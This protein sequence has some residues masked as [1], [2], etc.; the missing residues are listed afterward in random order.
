MTGGI[1]HILFA[2]GDICC[3]ICV[4]EKCKG[5]LILE[6]LWGDFPLYLLYTALDTH[7][8]VVDVSSYRPT[9]LPQYVEL[10][11]LYTY[12]LTFNTIQRIQQTYPSPR[13]RLEYGGFCTIILQP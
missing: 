7:L 4:V 5:T 6:R 10:A 8:C 11:C 1:E 12:F 2:A 9:K 3:D 13:M